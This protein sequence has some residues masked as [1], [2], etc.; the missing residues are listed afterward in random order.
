MGKVIFI[1][2]ALIVLATAAVLAA[3][4]FGGTRVLGSGIFF[5]V[6]GVLISDP[7]GLLLLGLGIIGL[8]RLGRKKYIRPF[9][10]EETVVKKIALVFSAFSLI[11]TF[12]QRS[13]CLHNNGQQHHRLLG[14]NRGWR[15]FYR[16]WRCDWIP[17]LQY[18]PDGCN[19]IRG[20]IGPL[21][22]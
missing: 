5:P 18:R 1:I 14:G 4:S 2:G 3:P 19:Q 16:L 8:A 12:E 10:E 15:R 6:P 11:T 21:N 22:W 9:S 7:F 13:L 20:I 17:L